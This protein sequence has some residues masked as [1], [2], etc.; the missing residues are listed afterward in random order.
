MGHGYKWT[1]DNSCNRYNIWGDEDEFEDY[2]FIIE[3]SSESIIGGYTLGGFRNQFHHGS[4]TPVKPE[5]IKKGSPP[6]VHNIE[7]PHCALLHTNSF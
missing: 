7:E 3:E 6:D 1:T 4:L 2:D 5:I